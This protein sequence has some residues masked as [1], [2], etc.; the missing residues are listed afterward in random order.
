MFPYVRYS[1]PQMKHIRVLGL[2]GYFTGELPYDEEFDSLGE[3]L[4]VPP[5]PYLI[6]PRT[7]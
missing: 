4:I 1:L 2:R 7:F 3:F 6:Y 5:V